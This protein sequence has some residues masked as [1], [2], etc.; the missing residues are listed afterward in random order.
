MATFST[1]SLGAGAHAMADIVTAD[2]EVLAVVRLAADQQM[3]VRVV[4]VPVLGGDPVEPRLEVALMSATGS[5]VK[6]FRS[7]I[8]IASSGLTM[9]W[10]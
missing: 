4:G 1:P 9:N 5:R 10:K 8:L 6:A 2:D 3:D 7:S